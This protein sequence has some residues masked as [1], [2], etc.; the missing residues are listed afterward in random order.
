MVTNF[1][2]IIH[3]VVLTIAIGYIFSGYIKIPGLYSRGWNWKGIKFAMLVT[4]PAIILHE[5]SHKFVG[6]ALGYAAMFHIWWTGLGIGLVLRIIGSPFLL[7]APGYVSVAPST[8]LELGAIAFA[9]PFINLILFVAAIL[10]LKLKKRM[11]KKVFLFWHLTK[12]INMWL[13]IFN[14]LPIPPL[15]GSKVFTALFGLF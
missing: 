1:T 14:M 4:A 6:L 10:V 11:K 15:D 12:V 8:P 13:F 2:E 3:I 5:L 7:L 9:G